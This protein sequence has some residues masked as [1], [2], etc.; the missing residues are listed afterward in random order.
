MFK[1][2][3]DSAQVSVFTRQTGGTSDSAVVAY[4]LQ[5]ALL[6]VK[7]TLRLTVSQSYLGVEATLPV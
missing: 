1:Y 6:Q 2:R 3:Y 5:D 7:V 4:L